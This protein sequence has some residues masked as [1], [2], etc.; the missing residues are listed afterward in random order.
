MPEPDTPIFSKYARRVCESS[1]FEGPGG[2]NAPKMAL[3][4]D[5]KIDQ[6]IDLIFNGFL[7]DVGGPKT[8]TKASK[9][10]PKNESKK[11]PKL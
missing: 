8:L 5:A 10:L 9:N 3:Q 1:I 11:R 7:I 4:I 2:Q 6:K